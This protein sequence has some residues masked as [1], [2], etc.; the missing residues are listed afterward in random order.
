MELGE[1]DRKGFLS[2]EAEVFMKENVEKHK[3]WFDLCNELNGLAQKTKYEFEIH[4]QNEQEKLGACLFIR[5]LNDFQSVV[6]LAKYG[7][8]PQ[9]KVILRSTF[10][11]LCLLIICSED[12]SFASE[13]IK[14]CN[15]EQLKKLKNVRGVP[16]QRSPEHAKAMDEV[17]GKSEEEIE[18]ENIKGMKKRELAERAGLDSHYNT[19]YR[20]LCDTTHVSIYSLN[21][22]SVFDENKLKTFNWGPIDKGLDRVLLTTM[23]WLIRSLQ[24]A[25]KLFKIDIKKQLDNIEAKLKRLA[26]NS[27]E[28]K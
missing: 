2:E 27:K 14:I 24:S 22:Y 26:A 16:L 21:D 10:E 28:H 23:G 20:E 5:G 15:K 9:S 18:G 6:I 3:E 11:A 19:A 13:Y 12:S 1:F 17:I 25:C 4:T 8:I 7:L